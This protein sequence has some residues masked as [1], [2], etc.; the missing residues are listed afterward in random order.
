MRALRRAVLW[1]ASILLAVALAVLAGM[2]VPRPLW[3]SDDDSPATRR[4]LVLTNPIH[5]DIA[6]PIVPDVL[7]RF[8]FLEQPGIPLSNPAA[9]WLIFGWGGRAFYLETPTWADLKPMPV[10]KALT[11]DRSVMHADL[12]GEIPEPRPA[13]KAF[14]I[15]EE[16]FD[17]LVAFI[18]QASNAWTAIRWWCPALPTAPSTAFTTPAARSTR[19]SAAT[20]GRR[21]LCERPAS[22]PGGGVRCPETSPCRCGSTTSRGGRLS[23]VV[24]L[25]EARYS[26]VR[27]SLP[28]WR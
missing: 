15:G 19:C 24:S 20:H 1:I 18:E 21:G 7:E 8:A 4:I 12:F 25:R 6:I 23:C 28:R 9:R 27:R 2:L 3:P 16:D 17:R 5:T 11:L 13:V 10:L 14:E 26:A 22:A